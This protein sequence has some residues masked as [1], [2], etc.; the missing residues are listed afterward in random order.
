M[1]HSGVG[2][3]SNCLNTV[4]RRQ[5]R[6]R[7]GRWGT[8]LV[9]SKRERMPFVA[10]FVDISAINNLVLSWDICYNRNYSANADRPDRQ[11]LILTKMLD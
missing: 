2:Y 11:G 3:S 6:G 7:G 1:T 9:R 8:I 4:V 10:V 5:K